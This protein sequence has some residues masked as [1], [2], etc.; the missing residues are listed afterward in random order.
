MRSSANV[1]NFESCLD[2]VEIGCKGIFDSSSCQVKYLGII[3]CRPLPSLTIACRL[4]LDVLHWSF[5]Q[6]ERPSLEG[7]FHFIFLDGEKFAFL[8]ELITI[9]V[10]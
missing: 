6:N 10:V 2:M 3:M 8:E 7:T 5:P 1:S 4:A 9:M